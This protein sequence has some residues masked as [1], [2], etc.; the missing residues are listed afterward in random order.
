ME[1]P[2][3]KT[4]STPHYHFPLTIMSIKPTTQTPA[5]YNSEPFLELHRYKSPFLH[6]VLGV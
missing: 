4:S 6:V 1:Y 2:L 3:I 5:S